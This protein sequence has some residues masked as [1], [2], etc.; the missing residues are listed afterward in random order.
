MNTFDEAYYINDGRELTQRILPVL[1]HSPLVAFFFALVYIPVQASHYWLIHSS[2]IGRFVLF[3]LL[4]LSSYLI[5]KQMS[6]LSYPP[7][8]MI[9]FLLVSPV[10]PAIITNGSD[11]LFAAMSGL[12]FWKILSFYNDR[13]IKH[14]WISSVFVALAALS[15]NEG[16]V[17]FLIFIPF[18]VLLS[19]PIKRTGILLTAWIIPFII[20]VGGY[21]TIYSLSTKSFDLGIARRAYSSFEQGQGQAIKYLPPYK[22]PLLEGQIEARQLY[23]TPEENN[24]SVITAIR[25]NPQAYLKRIVE[26][27]KKV[28]KVVL[29][30]YGGWLGFIFFLLA[31]RG[32]IEIVRKKMYLFLCILLIWPSYLFLNLLFLYRNNH[33][34][35][36]FFI[37]FFLASVGVT[38]ILSDIGDRKEYFFWFLTLVGLGILGIVMNKPLNKSLLFTTPIILLFGL[39]GA[40]IVIRQYRDI[41]AIKP[42]GLILVFCISVSLQVNSYYNGSF[43]RFRKLGIAPDE[44]A[45]MFMRENFEPGTRVGTYA[46]RYVWGAKMTYVPMYLNLRYMTSGQDLSTWIIDQNLKAIYMNE[47]FRRVE[48]S[49]CALIERQ[50]GK[51][52]EIAFTSDE[53]AVQ[54]LLVTDTFKH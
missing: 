1:A 49:V 15:R 12:S 46:P 31:S 17:L 52:L 36:A 14:L 32:I 45:A 28:P 7:L 21:I 16:L 33:F 3:G 20:I 6:R 25:R 34:L 29:S 35:S 38:S 43:G 4:W 5:A 24:Y 54:V 30:V 47:S 2:T 40:W 42:I 10:L 37:V 22:L 53:G 9:A 50:I 19:K 39:W 27:T 51:S 13:K 26:V 48:P 8:I 18:C 44:K 23:G 41:R 11:A